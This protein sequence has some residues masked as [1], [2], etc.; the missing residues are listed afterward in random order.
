MP[1]PRVFANQSSALSNAAFVTKAVSELLWWGCIRKVVETPKVC[2][3]LLVVSSSSG[4]QRLVIN[5][6]Y[7]NRYLW[8]DKFKYEDMHSAPAYFEVGHFINTFDLKLG[9]VC[10]L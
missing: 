10:S 4:K 7:I 5:L 3:P 8:K 9:I 6:R 2:S 1:G